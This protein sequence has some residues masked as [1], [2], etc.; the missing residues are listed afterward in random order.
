MK[1]KWR[2]EKKNEEMAPFYILLFA[3]S[4]TVDKKEPEIW[5]LQRIIHTPIIGGIKILKFNQLPI[6]IFESVK[7]EK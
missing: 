2:E 4:C 5:S 6:F 1:Q 7:T 3:F